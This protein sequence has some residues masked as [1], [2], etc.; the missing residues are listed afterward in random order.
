MDEIILHHYEISPFSEKIRKILAWKQIPWRGVLQPIIAPKP[1]LTP[2]TG[3]NRR[4]P[5]LQI[6]ADIYC[7]TQRIARVLDVVKP[8]R[9]CVPPGHAGAAEIIAHW[10]DHFIFLAAVPPAIVALVDVLPPDFIADR[11]AMS[12]G[13][14]LEAFKKA[15]PDAKNRLLVAFDWL[16]AEL[17]GRDFLVGDS[18]S[19]ADAACFH[20]I[21]FLRA[22]PETFR[23]VTD[24]P[25]LR[26]WFERIDALGNGDMQPM[27]PDEALAIARRSLA[28]TPEETDGSD[29]FGIKPGDPIRIVADDYGVEEVSGVAVV[30][31]AREIAVRREDPSVGEVTVHFPRVGYRILRG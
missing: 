6:G 29:P 16:E 3:G 30:V 8:E 9:P 15:A 14:S 31:T 4:I 18:F 11:K 2:L 26:R 17:A 24:R 23:G 20:P 10:G 21:W 28:M 7:D 13:F 25:G 27:E 19:I 5:V 12:P 22:V 1:H